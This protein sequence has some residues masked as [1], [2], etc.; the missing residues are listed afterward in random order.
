MKSINEYLNNSKI[1]S[2]LYLKS[3]SDNKFTL[4]QFDKDGKAISIKDVI[5][6][7]DNEAGIYFA[8]PTQELKKLQPLIKEETH[9]EEN[10]F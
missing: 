3:D 8:G 10:C 7:S 6:I 1:N 4:S 9:L 2:A 5:L